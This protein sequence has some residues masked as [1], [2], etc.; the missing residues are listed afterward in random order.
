MAE[1]QERGDTHSAAVFSFRSNAFCRMRISRC[2]LSF[3]CAIRITSAARYTYKSGL[4][5]HLSLPPLLLLCR[6][7]Y[8]RCKMHTHTQDQLHISPC[9]LSFSCAVCMISAARCNHTSQHRHKADG[10]V[11][12]TSRF[13]APRRWCCL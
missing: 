11:S 13:V 6:L 1:A 10:I 9:P 8:L 7:H 2:L 5:A 3:S 12:H 4:A